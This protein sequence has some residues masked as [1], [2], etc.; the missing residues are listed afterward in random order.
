MDKGNQAEFPPKA[1]PPSAN[2]CVLALLQPP[3]EACPCRNAWFR[4]GNKC[5]TG[6]FAGSRYENLLHGSHI[7]GDDREQ[8]QIRNQF[9][10]VV[11]RHFVAA[12]VV[13]RLSVCAFTPQPRSLVRPECSA[14]RVGG[15]WAISA[16]SARRMLAALPSRAFLP[17]WLWVGVHISRALGDK[18]YPVEPGYHPKSSSKVSPKFALL[19]R[20][21]P[22]VSSV[23]LTLALGHQVVQAVNDCTC[24]E[25]A[26]VVSPEGFESFHGG[27]LCR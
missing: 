13:A 12:V 8:L 1:G 19:S 27:R 10:E 4:A 21:V 24:F 5:P 9:P 2:C 18:G 22:R 16:S 15:T 25:L 23:S 7:P 20:A 14:L 3:I 11:G 17:P 26:F 6:P